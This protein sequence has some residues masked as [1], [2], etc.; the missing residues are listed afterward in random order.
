MNAARIPSVTADAAQQPK[1][2][3]RLAIEIDGESP[4]AT[5]AQA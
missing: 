5:R 4:A 2:F 3:E 1:R